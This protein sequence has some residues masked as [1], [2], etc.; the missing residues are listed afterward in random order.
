MTLRHRLV[1]L[2]QAAIRV[3]RTLILAVL[4]VALVATGFA[5]RAPSQTENAVA[6]I[7]LAGG[8]L[9][10]LCGDRGPDSA[11]GHADCLA[12]QI[13]AAA[14][15]PPATG[16]VLDLAHV[17]LAKVAAPRADCAIPR[18]L[19]PAHGPQGPPTV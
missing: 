17:M 15:L 6:A 19:D 14:D 8:S 1:M 12:C 16:A 7:L 5:H 2:R 11:P 9:A 18:R 10:D 4:A 3:H 13:T